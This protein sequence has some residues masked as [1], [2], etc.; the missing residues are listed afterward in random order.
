[1]KQIL[2]IGSLNMDLV[3]NV[4]RIPKIGETLLGDGFREIPGGKG[5][6][7]AV[8]IG[9]LGG[10]VKML[11]MVGEDSYAQ[12]LTQNLNK[13]S[14]DSELIMT[15][16]DN[17]TGIAM[18]MVSE[19]G[20]NSIVVVPGANFELRPQHILD[21]YFD[22]VDYVLAQLE[23]PLETIEQ[24]FAKAKERGITT[25]LNPAPAKKLTD[26][27][28]ANTDLLIPNESEFYELTSINPNSE[29][30][31]Q[32]GAKLLY[33]SGIKSILLTLGKNGAYY[34]D[35]QG[36]KF[37][38][39]AFCVDVVDTTAAGD[40]FIGGVI[41]KLS[42]DVPVNE[43]IEFGMKVGAITVGRYGAQSSLPTIDEV[44]NFEGVKRA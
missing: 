26:K 16:K 2:V 32:K 19:D 38:S 24:A 22:D 6:N 40:S 13:N 42:Q 28:I 4:T 34:M 33:D 25:V 5:A 15:S 39:P 31:I 8:A 23:T 20:D 44:D 7:Q 41:T 18:I 37:K 14:V 1:M 30:E 11:G 43:A 27:L 36:N 9:R 3:T 17:S 35:K 29:E 10:N 21:K 12:A